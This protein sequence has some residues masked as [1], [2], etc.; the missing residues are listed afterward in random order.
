MK[1]YLFLILPLFLLLPLL[2]VQAA[3]LYLKSEQT[4]FGV[5]DTVTLDARVQLDN[6]EEC[7]NA[8]SGVVGFDHNILELTDFS[9]GDS[10]LTLWLDLPNTASMAD[11]NHQERLKFS[12]GIPGGY[13][14]LI[15]G[16]TGDSNILGKLVFKVK[17]TKVLTGDIQTKLQFMPETQVLLND[18]LGTA[19][20]LVFKPIDLTISNVKSDNQA[21]EKLKTADNIQPEPFII[22]VLKNQ[23]IY[24]NKSYIVWNTSDKQTGIDH[25]EVTES[26]S[27]NFEKNSWLATI[28]NLFKTEP[29]DVWQR[30]DSPYVLK[31]QSLSK[32]IRVKAFDKA[33]NERTSEYIPQ[34]V[35][36]TSVNLSRYFGPI[37]LL[38]I[39]I[40]T[41]II[42][43]RRSKKQAN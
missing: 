12:G 35:V 2:S 37:V 31:D 4:N 5:G 28:K 42:L 8:V 29:A 33:G 38:L 3:T 41:I 40:L 18:G 7:I 10:I 16:D 19:A 20:K 22:Q 30:A 39:I 14:G 11:A 32:I 26:A 36:P 25:Y 43:V 17:P 34:T 1:K 27:N 23:G 9:S 21:W 15:P 13:C 6:K 24:D